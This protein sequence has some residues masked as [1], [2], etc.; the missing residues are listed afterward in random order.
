MKIRYYPETDS[1][2]I[3]LSEKP[4]VDS[5]EVAEDTVL[6]FDAK[7]NVVGIEIYSDA[8]RRLDLSR[9][10]SERKDEKGRD[11]VLAVKTDFMYEP[12]EPVSEDALS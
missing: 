10:S 6:D 8:A 12:I 5:Q 4:G 11:V 7:G 9:I 2:Y 3:S 1:A